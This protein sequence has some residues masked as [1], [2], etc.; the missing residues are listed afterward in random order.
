MNTTKQK[1]GRKGGLRTVERHGKEH[2]QAIGRRGAAAT[3]KK[4]ALMPVDSS[5]YA[6]VERAT[7]KIRAIWCAPWI[8]LCLALLLAGCKPFPTRTPTET[9]PATSAPTRQETNTARAA[10]AAAARAVLSPTPAR[11]VV[12]TG[13]NAGTVNVRSGPGMTYSVVDVVQEGQ[14]LPLYGHPV[15]G[16]QEVTTPALVNGW[17]YVIRWCK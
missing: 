8:V 4:Y 1:A 10:R 13:Y 2:M 7:G 17:F 12:S 11:C 3:W 14:E 15:D 6:M 5:G 16:W 9:P